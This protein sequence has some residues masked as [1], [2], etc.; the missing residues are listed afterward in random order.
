MHT[1]N[2]MTPFYKVIRFLFLK[3]L[4][5]IFRIHVI[6]G[7][8]MLREQGCLLCANHTSMLDVLILSAGL[9][10]QIRYMAK[11]ELF[12]I[13]LLK[14]LITAL[15]AYPVNRGGAD[16]SSIKRTIALLGDGHPVGIFPQG[17]RHPGADPS[18][19]PIKN[20]IGM[21]AWHAKTPV[22]PLYIQTKGNRVRFFQKTELIVG[23]PIS[24]EDLG[25]TGSGTAQYNAAAE[26]VFRDIC[27]LGGYNRPLP[28]PAA[29]K[30]KPE[31]K[32]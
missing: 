11:K 22:V 4:R 12:S 20:G 2:H 24:F 15:G 13:P 21:I 27:A 32:E 9:D 5:A 26:R 17:T 18:A 1:E 19:T 8:N 31:G 23:R 25:M 28:A 7:D 16:V 14:Q 10:C 30:N 3:P 29:P 6:D